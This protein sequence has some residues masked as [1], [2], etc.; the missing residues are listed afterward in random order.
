MLS[1]RCKP[2]S[3]RCHRLIEKSIIVVHRSYYALC[4]SR[5]N[6]QGRGNHMTC[7]ASESEIMHNSKFETSNLISREC[8]ENPQ[9]AFELFRNETRLSE[10]DVSQGIE[11]PGI[12]VSHSIQV[13]Q[14]IRSLYS[15][16]I[17]HPARNLCRIS[18]RRLAFG[19]N[20]TR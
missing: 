18:N 2:H 5:Y 19:T 20:K 11:S 6:P 12:I 3:K 7:I 9:S 15:P 4:T 8:K 1:F 17:N 16:P 13:T 10:D 14:S